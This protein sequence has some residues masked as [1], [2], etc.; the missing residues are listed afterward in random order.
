MDVTPFLE[1]KLT[2]FNV[3]IKKNVT[4]NYVYRQYT[5]KFLQYYAKFYSIQT[6]HIYLYPNFKKMTYS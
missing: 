4:F 2:Q 1:L 3:K 6:K 5:L